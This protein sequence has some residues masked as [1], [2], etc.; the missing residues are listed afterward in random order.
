MR[1]RHIGNFHESSITFPLVAPDR[2]APSGGIGSF[3]SPR[4]TFA[5]FAGVGILRMERSAGSQIELLR[6]LHERLSMPAAAGNHEEA[7]TPYPRL[8]AAA[9][10]WRENLD[11]DLTFENLQ[12]LIAIGM[13]LPGRWS[14]GLGPEHA[15]MPI[16]E[17][18]EFMKLHLRQAVGD[19][20]RVEGDQVL[21]LHVKPRRMDVEASR[22]QLRTAES[23]IVE[24]WMVDEGHE[25][26]ILAALDS[27]VKILRGLNVGALTG[28]NDICVGSAR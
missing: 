14:A 27:S 1:C 10:V 23:D 26:H 7:A 6:T 4:L 21:L 25:E 2:P 28:R 17:S 24:S 19:H 22:S 18:R 16:V 11:L 12:H 9:P 20:G 5:F 3:E 15:G 8:D 13:H